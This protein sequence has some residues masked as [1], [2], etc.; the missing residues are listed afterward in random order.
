MKKP[1]RA[2][3]KAVT[4]PKAKSSSKIVKSD[5]KKI[6]PSKVVKAKGKPQVAP[7]KVP[8]KKKV[9]P[10][11]SQDDKKVVKGKKINLSPKSVGIKKS[12][13]VQPAPVVKKKT[14]K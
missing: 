1:D 14:K 10:A 2:V 12:G 4:P 11:K 7:V 3:K 9:L 6:E 8:E 13:S 5:P